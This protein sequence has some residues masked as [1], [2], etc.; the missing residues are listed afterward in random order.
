MCPEHGAVVGATLPVLLNVDPSVPEP[1][2][3]HILDQVRPE[4]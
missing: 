2:P 1:T 3:T 4:V